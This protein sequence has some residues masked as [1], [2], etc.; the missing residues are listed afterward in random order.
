MILYITGV[1][2]RESKVLLIKPPINTSANGE[3]YGLAFRANGI[4]LPIAVK[5]VSTTGKTSTPRLF[6]L[7]LLSPF[8][9][10]GTGW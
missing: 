5:E 8:L 1:T 3:I 10:L 2:I 7:P 9:R 4:K 6:R